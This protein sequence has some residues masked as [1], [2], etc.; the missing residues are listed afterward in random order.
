MTLRDR[1]AAALH[2]V[3]GFVTE[4]MPQSSTRLIAVVF[5]LTAC[6]CAPAAIVFAFKHPNAWQSIAAIGG[7]TITALVGGVS[8]ALAVR[9]QNPDDKAGDGT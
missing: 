1:F 4:Q 2:Y 3:S 7:T 9:K 5:S 6:A 8:V